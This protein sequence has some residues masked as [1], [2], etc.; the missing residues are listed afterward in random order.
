MT[1]AIMSAFVAVL[2]FI[3]FCA[4]Y[5]FAMVG[6]MSRFLL[7]P[8]YRKHRPT[9]QGIGKYQFPSGKGL[10][11]Q[12]DEKYRKYLTKYVLFSY[13]DQKY[14]TCRLCG[15]VLS[16]RYEIVAY[17]HRGKQIKVLECAE[18]VTSQWQTKSVRVPERTAYVSVIL[19]RVNEQELISTLRRTSFVKLAVFSV[20]TVAMTAAVGLLARTVTLSISDLFGLPWDLAPGLTLI[21]STVVGLHVVF[22]YLLIN[23]K[24]IFGEDHDRK[25]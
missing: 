13:G 8:S 3:A 12:P 17:D 9:D 2:A 25:K 22:L 16:L 24:Q 15:D 20:L 7:S 14:V 11:F 5:I 6:P 23:R 1:D 19:K 4:I 21:L 10:T 18:N